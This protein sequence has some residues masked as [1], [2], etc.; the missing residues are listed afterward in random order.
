MLCDVV[1]DSVVDGMSAA[2][3]N[4][5]T[6][7]VAVVIYAYIVHIAMFIIVFVVTTVHI[8]INNAATHVRVTTCSVVLDI[9]VVDIDDDRDTIAHTSV[10]MI[11]I[12]C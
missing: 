1:A 11:C 9:V 2:V 6:D 8:T 3:L 10:I 4:V 5:V 12:F 7:D